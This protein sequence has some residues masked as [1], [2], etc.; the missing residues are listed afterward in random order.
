MDKHGPRYLDSV[1]LF[2]FVIFAIREAGS[3]MRETEV[4]FSGPLSRD[5][6]SA[7]IRASGLLELVIAGYR[8]CA[9]NFDAFIFGYLDHRAAVVATASISLSDAQVAESTSATMR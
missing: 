4:L 7:T 2:M 5:R 8:P 1:R 3:G 9:K 6:R